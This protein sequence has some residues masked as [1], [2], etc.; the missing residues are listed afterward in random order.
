VTA[1]AGY[2]TVTL[3]TFDKHS[4]GCRIVVIATTLE[5]KFTAIG[6]DPRGTGTGL[7]QIWSGRDTNIDAPR[8]KEDS[9]CYVHYAY[10]I[11]I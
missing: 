8:K 1:V 7:L 6:V 2:V 4:N 11:V 9:H 5:K 10:D 3:M